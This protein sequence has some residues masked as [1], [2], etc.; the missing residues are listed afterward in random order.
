MESKPYRSLSERGIARLTTDRINMREKYLKELLNVSFKDFEKY[1]L[2]ERR[3]YPEGTILTLIDAIK[4][5]LFTHSDYIEA[6]FL[7]QLPNIESNI[8]NWSPLETPKKKRRTKPN[9]TKK[10]YLNM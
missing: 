6:L 7:K 2:Q 1:R 3:Q 5:G 8:K 10:K 4:A 9:Q